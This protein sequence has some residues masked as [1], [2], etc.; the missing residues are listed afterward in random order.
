MYKPDDKIK[1][2]YEQM[3]ELTNSQCLKDCKIRMGFC[4]SPEYCEMAQ[5]IAKEVGVELKETRDANGVPGQL[6]NFSKK[7][8]STTVLRRRS[9][10]SK[11][12]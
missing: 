9:P 10:S 12:R 3:A 8:A 11:I 7:T 6:S 4:C 2:L 5:T 1:R